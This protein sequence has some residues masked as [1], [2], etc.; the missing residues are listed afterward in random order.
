MRLGLVGG[1]YRQLCERVIREMSEAFPEL[2]EAQGLITRAVDNED[3]TF[4]RTI[5]RGLRLIEENK[6]WHQA[7]G[8][9]VMP[10]AVVFKLYDTFGFPPDLTRVIGE[11]QGFTVDEAGFERE[12]SEQRTRSSE[13]AGSGDKAV[14]DIYKKLREELGPTT[15]RGYDTTCEEGRVLALLDDKGARILVAPEGSTVEII[16]DRTPFYG[17]AGGQI[18]DTGTLRGA[19]FEVQVED[20]QKPGGDLIVHRGKVVKGHVEPGEEAVLT[21][22]VDRRDAI[23]ANHSATHLLHWALKH[24]LGDHVSQKGSLVAPDRLRFDF[25][26]FAPMTDD[27]EAPR[28]GAGEQRGAQEPRGRDHR[29]RLRRGQEARRGGPLR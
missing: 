19:T 7:G 3:E 24:V 11:E 12:M 8:Q 13:F 5:D 28:R 21:V 29:A 16:T 17:E 2:K 6:S 20:T 14:A 25:S 18:G 10:G 4:R 27:E 22:D 15:F 23:R 1:S 26:H 9:R